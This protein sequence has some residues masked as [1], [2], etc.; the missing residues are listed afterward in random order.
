MKKILFLSFTLVIS[1]TLMGQGSFRKDFKSMDGGALAIMQTSDGG[2]VIGGRIKKPGWWNNVPVLLKISSSGDSLWE[3]EIPVSFAYDEPY[4]KITPDDGFV[5]S[6]PYI[7]GYTNSAIVR[8]NPV[9]DTLWTKVLTDFVATSVEVPTLTEIDV[10]GYGNNLTFIKMDGSGNTIWEKYYITSIFVSTFC[11]TADDG[12]ALAG[13]PPNSYPEYPLQLS[14]TNSTGDISWSVQYQEDYLVTTPY[15]IHQTSDNGYIICGSESDTGWNKSSFAFIL[16]ADNTG[17]KQWSQ[18]YT[19]GEDQF[20]SIQA[21]QPDGYIVC[22][23]GST[24]T[25]H[26]AVLEKISS[27][28][29]PVWRDT[30]QEGTNTYA[31]SVL[32]CTDGGYIFAGGYY[33]APNY[34]DSIALVIKTDANGVLSAPANYFTPI[35]KLVIYPEPCND[36][37]CLQYSF[38]DLNSSEGSLEIFNLTGQKI[39]SVP[40]TSSVLKR[41]NYKLDTHDLNPGQY[42]LKLRSGQTTLSALMIKVD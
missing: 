9:G 30:F 15:S 27:T 17:A 31:N 12:Y 37:T 23:H 22:G 13:S 2:Y 16:K 39:K 29:S 33:I 6:C 5:I 21:T 8:V 25:N 3:K 1:I 7:N 26:F 36:Y 41:G 10:L 34:G 38:P 4:F 20:S 40:M 42:I 32:P 11:K 19:A 14:K 28:G 18:T 35:Q 24:G